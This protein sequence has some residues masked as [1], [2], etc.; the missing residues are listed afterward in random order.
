MSDLTTCNYCKLQAVKRRYG[1]KNV[2]LVADR[3][4]KLG[5]YNVM[6]RESAEKPWRNAGMWLMEVTDHCVC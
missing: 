6:V 4:Y 1:A 2:K 5:G 3:D